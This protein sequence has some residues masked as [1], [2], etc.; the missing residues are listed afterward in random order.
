MRRACNLNE[1]L[2]TTQPGLRDI[3]GVE[4]YRPASWVKKAKGVLVMPRL[5][6]MSQEQLT[7]CGTRLRLWHVSDACL[8]V[9][10]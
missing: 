9:C 4:G 7:S 8:Q 2:I 1:G 6:S 5:P 3:E 10:F